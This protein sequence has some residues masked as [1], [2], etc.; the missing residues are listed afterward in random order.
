MHTHTQT[1]D[2]GTYLL[3]RLCVRVLFLATQRADGDTW[4]T[5]GTL[6]LKVSSLTSSDNY[7]SNQHCPW[8]KPAAGC[9]KMSADRSVR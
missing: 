1:T 2:V 8:H 3:M 9:V 4:N 6:S 5:S 7:A